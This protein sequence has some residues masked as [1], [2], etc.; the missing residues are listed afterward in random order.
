MYVAAKLP[1]KQILD[2]KKLVDE[3][4]NLVLSTEQTKRKSEKTLLLID[5]II[6]SITTRDEKKDAKSSKNKKTRL[7][8][9]P[10]RKSW[11]VK[12]NR[13]DR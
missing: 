9:R 6:A 11:I 4:F 8:K 10:L 7:C 12:K 13:P 1:E 5:H 2:L 3:T